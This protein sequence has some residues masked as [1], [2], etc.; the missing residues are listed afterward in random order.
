LAKRCVDSWN[1]FLPEYEIKRWD[2]RNTD[3]KLNRY[4]D[5]AYQAGQFAFVSDVV[6][7]HVLFREGGIYLD[8]D[9]EVLKSFDSFL[10]HDLFLGFESREVV[11]SCVIGAK[12]EHPFI[13]KLLNNYEEQDLTEGVSGVERIPNTVM[14]SKELEEMGLLLNNEKQTVEGITIYPN[15]FFCPK[16]YDQLNYEI[17]DNTI[18]IHHFAGSWYSFGTRLLMWVRL[19]IIQ[20]YF[21]YLDSPIVRIYKKLKLLWVKKSM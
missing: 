14:F 20:K 21:S 11:A 7:L 1:T 2:E 9:I 15:D 8:A 4:V 17:T 12:K 16:N 3:L 19:N 5:L 6:R 13:G 18:T 10:N